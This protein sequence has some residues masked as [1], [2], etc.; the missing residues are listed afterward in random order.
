MNRNEWRAIDIVEQS[1][2]ADSFERCNE[3][4]FGEDGKTDPESNIDRFDHVVAF[5]AEA[6]RNPLGHHD[7]GCFTVM[8]SE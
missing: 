3:N 8:F 4:R 2:L 6:F 7:R 1:H 5:L